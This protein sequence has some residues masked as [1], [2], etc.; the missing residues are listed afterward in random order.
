MIRRSDRIAGYRLTVRIG[1][2]DFFPAHIKVRGLIEITI[3]K[4]A[5]PGN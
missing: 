4:I 1:Y 5:V 2:M 3:E